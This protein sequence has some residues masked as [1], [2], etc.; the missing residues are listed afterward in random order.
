[1]FAYKVVTTT[2]IILF[3]ALI[4]FVTSK[5]ESRESK[6]FEGFIFLTYIAAIVG[7]WL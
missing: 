3:M 5:T 1:M 7:M 2:V 6:I 4:A